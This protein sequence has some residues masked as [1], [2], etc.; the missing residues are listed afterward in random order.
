VWLRLVPQ[1][2]VRAEGTPTFAMSARTLVRDFGAA[3]LAA[4]GV[5]AL[6]VFAAAAA[7]DVY[8]TRD[9]YLSIAAFHAWLELVML[10]YFVSA[11]F[12]AACQPPCAER[13]ESAKDVV[14]LTLSCRR[15]RF[16]ERKR[17]TAR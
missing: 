10:V 13:Y 11:G 6:V 8:R 7:V 2:D 3:P 1:E 17:T 12:G 15:I 4:I 9:L 16:E 5:T 14:R